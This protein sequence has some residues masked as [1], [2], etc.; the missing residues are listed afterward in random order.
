ML[1][2]TIS[3]SLE[4]QIQSQLSLEQIEALAEALFDFAELQELEAWLPN[5]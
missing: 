4:T 1:A 5:C 3:S 2:A